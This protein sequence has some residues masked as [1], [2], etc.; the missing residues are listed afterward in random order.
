MIC[1]FGPWEELAVL[2][3]G[4]VDVVVSKFGTPVVKALRVR[5]YALHGRC[6]NLVSDCFA[7]DLISDLRVLNDKDT[8]FCRVEIVTSCF[9]Y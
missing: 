3:V 9:F 6:V 4:D 7:V 5:K 8:A 1:E 2:V